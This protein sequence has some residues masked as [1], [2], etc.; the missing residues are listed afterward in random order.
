MKHNPNGAK[1]AYLTKDISLLHT[2]F[3]VLPTRQ[4]FLNRGRACSIC[5][6]PGGV[7]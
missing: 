1:I 5:A 2:I 7:S 3:L 6:M 4:C